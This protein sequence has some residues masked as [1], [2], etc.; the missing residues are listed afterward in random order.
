MESRLEMNRTLVLFLKQIITHICWIYWICWIPFFHSF[1]FLPYRI[2]QTRD[3]CFNCF[4]CFIFSE[5]TKQE[6]IVLIVF[7]VFLFQ[8]RPKNDTIVF[9]FICVY[10]SWN[11][12]KTE[13][14]LLFSLC[15][16]VPESTEVRDHCVHCFLFVC[17]FFGMLG[18]LRRRIHFPVG[19]SSSS[20]LS[21]SA[22][23]T[24]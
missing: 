22:V 15:A 10:F 20:T 19:S 6:T 16:L 24:V 13:T 8:N 5:P 2:D 21:S 18:G 11:R 9:I 1:H 23:I 14:I 7:I 17:V 12:P 4:H 3:K